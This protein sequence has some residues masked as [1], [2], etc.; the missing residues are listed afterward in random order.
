MKVFKKNFISLIMVLILSVGL[1]GIFP[2]NVS[3]DEDEAVKVGFFPMSGFQFYGDNGEHLGYNVDYLNLIASFTGWE[4]E[5]VDINSFDEGLNM[6]AEE[7]IDLIA[8]CLMNAD[9]LS[10]YDYSTFSM[11]TGYYALVSKAGNDAIGYMD[12]EQLEGKTVALAY[13]YP[14]TE[15]FLEYMN[16]TGINLVPVYYDTPEE[17]VRSM[18]T[19]ETDC[20]VTSLMAV[21]ED[22]NVIS[23]FY[24]APMYY[25]TYKDNTEFLYNLNTAMEQVI[26]TYPNEINK[27]EREYF[28]AYGMQFFTK[29]EQEFINNCP[30]LRL[31]YIQGR[32]PLS[33]T[34]D[35]TG[36]F[37]GISRKIFDKIALM[38]GLKFEYVPLPKGEVSAQFFIDNDIDLVSGV[39]NNDVNKEV[40][41]LSLSAPYLSSQKVFVGD[42]DLEFYENSDM[43]VA[44]STG[45]DNIIYELKK[46]YP[47]FEVIV[48]ETVEECFGAVCDGEADVL[49]HNQYTVDYLMAK[50]VYE[51]LTIIPAEG[52]EDELCFATVSFQNTGMS[53]ED[54]IMLIRVLDKAISGITDEQLEGIIVRENIKYRYE[55]D[56]ADTVYK[57][58]Y[59]LIISG[60]T[61]LLVIGIFVYVILINHHHAQKHREEAHLMLIQ[62][63]RYQLVTDNYE[64]MIYEISTMDNSGISSDKIKETFGWEIPGY[65]DSL[66]FDNMMKALHVHPDDVDKIYEKY[67]PTLS[68]KGIDSVVAQLGCINGEYIWCELT[69]IPL[70]D[71]KDNLISYVGK[72]KNIDESIRALQEQNQKLQETTQQNE[73]LEELLMNAILENMTD[74]MKLNLK[75]WES[76]FYVIEDGKIAEKP[77]NMEW[78]ELFKYFLS[79]LSPEDK[80]RLV[81]IGRKER[82]MDAQVGESFM[83]HYK[84]FYDTYKRIPSDKEFYY[85][86]RINIAMVNEEK[87]AIITNIDDTDVMTRE[88]EYIEQKDRFANELI[89]SQQ[90]LCCAV[91]DTYMA[92]L[93]IDTENGAMYAVDSNEQGMIEIRSLDTGWK[94]FCDKELLPYTDASDRKEF[95]EYCSLE[96]FKRSEPG[97]QIDIH[98]KATLDT[99]NFDPCDE[100]NWYTFNFRVL[101]ENGHKVVTALLFCDTEKIKT[102]AYKNQINEIEIRRKKMNALIESADE[103]L[104]EFDLANNVC[105]VT[106]NEQNFLGWDLNRKISEITIENVQNIW[107]VHPEDRIKTGDGA[108]QILNKKTPVAK[109]IRVRK[110]DG[111]YVWC[112]IN[113]VPII[114]EDGRVISIMCQIININEMMKDKEQTENIVSTDDL[115]GLLTEQGLKNTTDKYLKEHSAKNDAFIIIDLD[116][117]KSINENM[118]RR[119]GDKA[120]QDTA[121]KLQ[122]IFSNYDYIGRFNGDEF[123]VFVKNIPIETLEDKLEW[124]IEKLKDSYSFNGKITQISASIG[125]AYCMT[126]NTEYGELF[127]L[128]DSAVYEAKK[129]GRS[130]YI[131][132]RYF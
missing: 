116:H 75:T 71:E 6:L 44:I 16:A 54:S 68:V 96:A 76:V 33:F 121:R 107:G 38:T 30:T 115:T 51:N 52:L 85:T 20:S 60:F 14:I 24:S 123:G 61:A 55:L 91:S 58:R 8:P 110:S 125:A 77:T 80:P 43:K 109:S 83:Y 67:A 126:D 108:Q 63:K 88:R 87:V 7:K 112:K 59:V 53:R 64:D 50:P 57:Y 69:M 81:S 47:N 34:S 39:E 46:K 79:F 48:Y 97:T 10:K 13:N 17:A 98:L 128:A 103:L 18:L 21:T 117:F 3:G 120:I 56:F 74:V 106:G 25:L 132:K 37:A 90:F 35:N 22:Y 122:V 86:I 131:I 4:Y 95:I 32:I 104:Y 78:D 23:K 28:P 119:I 15:E 94:E 42:K 82:L 124:A 113:A 70:R 40:N 31:A 49:L 1:L 99:L 62:K 93:K 19:G 5:Y 92:A 105:I 72:I 89:A 73:N 29:E 102:E 111:S 114:G 41:G 100:T 101:E 129:T 118:D 130:R 36:E 9:R 2:V 84:S 12:Y 26:N 127:R 65:I 27:L 45:S 66:T 11:G